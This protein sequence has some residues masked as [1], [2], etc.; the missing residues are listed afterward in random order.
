MPSSACKKNVQSALPG[1]SPDSRAVVRVL[2]C[3]NGQLTPTS[4]A[5]WLGL[6]TRYQ[7]ARLLRRGGLPPFEDLAAWTRVLYWL[8]QSESTGASLLQLWRRE[9]LCPSA[10]ARV[11]RPVSG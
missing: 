11:G 5:Q 3:C 4:V 6:R 9:R 1:L 8:R 7:V 2:G 10:A